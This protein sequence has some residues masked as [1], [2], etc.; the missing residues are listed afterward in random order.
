MR[1]AAR[2][3]LALVLPVALMGGARPSA[4]I[5]A[6]CF[7]E[8]YDLKPGMWYTWKTDWKLGVIFQNRGQQASPAFGFKVAI[9]RWLPGNKAY[10][11]TYFSVNTAGSVDSNFIPVPPVDCNGQRNYTFDM[12]QVHSMY[13]GQKALVK[14]V[15]DRS[16]RDADMSNNN[17]E[18]VIT[19]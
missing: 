2:A 3:V 7:Y 12:S 14:L 10:T 13:A 11:T 5:E 18:F 1:R 19:L 4:L 17:P 16:L 8:T 9:Y 6:D 15:F